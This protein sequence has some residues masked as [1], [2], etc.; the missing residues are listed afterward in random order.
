MVLL[1]TLISSSLEG[2]LKDA[3]EDSLLG[4]STFFFEHLG[5]DCFATFSSPE[6]SLPA[7]ALFFDDLDALEVFDEY[8]ALE[9]LN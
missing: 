6:S 9:P 2:A 7:S 1:T 8:D 3:F 4:G 5:L